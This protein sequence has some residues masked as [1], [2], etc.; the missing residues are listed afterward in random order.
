MDFRCLASKD[1]HVLL[2]NNTKLKVY[3]TTHDVILAP[4][5]KLVGMDLFCGSLECG[6]CLLPC[7]VLPPASCRGAPRAGAVART[8]STH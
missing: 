5:T 4:K 7:P 2:Q 6:H 8:R 3:P 1:F